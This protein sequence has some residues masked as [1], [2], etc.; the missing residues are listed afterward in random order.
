MREE[1]GY[2]END[3]NFD[4]GHFEQ[5]KNGVAVLPSAGLTPLSAHAHRADSSRGKQKR[6]SFLTESAKD[7]AWGFHDVH[8][9]WL[10]EP[11]EF[12]V[13]GLA[14]LGQDAGHDLS[15]H[16]RAALGTVQQT[17]RPVTGS[18]P[19][20][21]GLVGARELLARSGRAGTAVLVIDHDYLSVP[22]A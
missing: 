14:R 17:F 10:D 16:S 13:N 18:P 2:E 11:A 8:R 7:F 20:V 15:P 5:N 6:K 22:G 12:L 9:R 3:Q 21:A 1:R 19:L 4:A